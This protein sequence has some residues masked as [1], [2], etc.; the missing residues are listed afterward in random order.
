MTALPPERRTTRGRRWRLPLVVGVVAMLA[1]A[2][3]VFAATRP[4]AT[5]VV[6]VGDEVALRVPLR[7]EPVWEV[8]WQH[9]VAGILVRDTF[10]WR[11]GRM[12]LT[13]TRTPLLD[14]AGLGHTP[15]EGELRRDG[16]D[17]WIAGIDRVI[18]G[19]AYTLRIGSQRAPTT[20]VHRG[21]SYSLTARHAG[22]SA[23]IEVIPR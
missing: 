11:D 9:S 18:P 10:A 21:R 13:D 1:L 15:G 23:R 22:A 3:A 16:D 20:L 6:R 14:V 17:H 2:L 4:A 7:G 5:L 8:H 19:G 12:V